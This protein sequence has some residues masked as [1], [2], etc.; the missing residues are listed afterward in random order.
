MQIA[1]TVLRNLTLL[2]IILM[3]AIAIF[4]NYSLLPMF[5]REVKHTLPAAKKNIEMRKETASQTQAPSIEDY[6]IIAEQNL[7]HPSR[8]IVTAKDAKP[9]TE[10]EFVLYGTLITDDTSLAFLE[11]M[12]SPYSTEGRGKRQ[13]ALSR[14]ATLSGYTLSEIYH[15]KVVMVRGEE[16]IVLNVA[17]P[18]KRP[19]ET[20]PAVSV[21]KLP[22][23]PM[24]QQE[25]PSGTGRP[26]GI[27]M[28]D[29]PSEQAPEMLPKA[30]E[31][32]E[33]IIKEKLG[34]LRQYPRR[35][36]Q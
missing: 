22:A 7:F 13:R 15:D 27:I 4:V 8:T 28:K 35:G 2:N 9:E 25:K 36:N 24:S 11:D 21:Q 26:P 12:K 20:P 32:I 1:K 23:T 30:R 6:T 10:P 18:R 33:A 19:T 34:P 5:N 14:G 29:A 3:A 16:Q 31:A 17:A